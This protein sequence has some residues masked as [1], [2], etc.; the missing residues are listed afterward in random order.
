MQRA[1]EYLSPLLL[2]LQVGTKGVG[3]GYRLARERERERGLQVS[4][5]E[6]KQKEVRKRDEGESYFMGTTKKAGKRC[7][8]DVS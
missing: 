6:E 4:E 8:L 7:H 1:D 5:R 2:W 3:E